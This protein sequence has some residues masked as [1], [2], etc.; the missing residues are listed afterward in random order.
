[1]YVRNAIIIAGLLAVTLA[2]LV[3][4]TPVGGAVRAPIQ[5]TLGISGSHAPTPPSLVNFQGLLTDPGTG[6]P[7]A[8]G[9]YSLRFSV[10][11]ALAAGSELWNE[12]QATVAVA[13][14]LFSVQL[15]SSTAFPSDLFADT[16][17][18]LEVKVDADPAL[19]P[20]QEL[21]SVPYAIHAGTADSANT[22]EIAELADATSLLG[23]SLTTIVGGDRTDGVSMT[24][25]EDGL[26]IVAAFVLLIPP[27]L[28]VTHCGNVAC[29]AGNTVTT[30]D[31]AVG[32]FPSITIGA[33][34]LPII[35]YGGHPIK[36][37]H[38][39]NVACSSGNTVTTVAADS[40]FG[41]S[42]TIGTD[43]LPVI[44]TVARGQVWVLHCGNVACSAGNTTTNIDSSTDHFK[45]SITIGSD[46]LPVMV[47]PRDGS[48]IRVL[49]C[50][51]FACSSGNTVTVTASNSSQFASITIGTDG[52]PIFAFDGG[53][54][55]EVAHCGN[56]DCSAGNTFT[57]VDTVGD[58]G[59]FPAI[60]IGAD[61]LPLVTYFRFG[62][63]FPLRVAHCGNV[64][65][66]ANNVTT[67]VV[68]PATFSSVKIGTDGLPVIISGAGEGIA[69]V[70]HCSNRFCLPWHRAR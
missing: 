40:D 8:D 36:V 20:R 60:T 6:D 53:G 9:D 54:D 42:I 55:L 11:D 61:G 19:A 64:A 47:F 7:V 33:D 52:L 4:A 63:P 13:D 32:D 66:S 25:G 50:G 46:G 10:W 24:I 21:V 41:P 39:G 2:V 68:T 28:V 30:V 16:P 37:A 3:T 59:N 38:C 27:R 70:I 48:T 65:C 45:A 57:T 35:A 49:H 1:M 22:A 67:T 62:S 56:L 5:R 34:G 23:H 12:T 18:Y 31:G 14:G 17:R 69:K 51:N 26:P 58:T 44:G 43:G 15:G 29:T